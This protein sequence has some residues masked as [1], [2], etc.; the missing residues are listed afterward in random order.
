MAPSFYGANFESEPAS[1]RRFSTTRPDGCAYHSAFNGKH[2]LYETKVV[3]PI[4]AS[5]GAGPARQ[6]QAGTL[7]AFG[8]S[9]KHFLTKILGT[10]SGDG[11]P[12]TGGD[13]LFALARGHTVVPLI[14][15]V[16]GGLAPCANETLRDLGRRK[17]GRLDEP[18]ASWSAR[19]FVAY[20][21]QLLSIAIAYGVS[22]ELTRGISAARFQSGTVIGRRW[23]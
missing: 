21:G 22:G 7:C 19:S 9:E 13:Y 23:M 11:A 2:V 12:P 10:P 14:H 20:H 18:S 4:A 8:N 3:A 17:Q 16:F 5:S 6:A 15:E 1:W